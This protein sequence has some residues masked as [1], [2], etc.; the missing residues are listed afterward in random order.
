MGLA[1]YAGAFDPLTNGHVDIAERAA[2]LFERLIIGVFDTPAK[3]LLFSTEERLDLFQ[4]TV[5]HM[6]NVEVRTYSR[7]TVD[8]ASEVGAVTMIR[9][10]RSITDL[11]YEVAMVMMNRKLHPK[12]DTVFLYTSQEFQFVSSTLVK[13]VAQYGGDVTNWVPHHVAAALRERYQTAA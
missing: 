7:L 4:K 8:F 1:V 10:L 2:S 3:S 11:D 5:E 12:I 9:G 6:P 13:E